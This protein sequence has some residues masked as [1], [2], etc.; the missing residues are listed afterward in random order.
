MSDANEPIREADEGV[1]LSVYLQPRAKKNEIVGLHNGAIKIRITA[2]PVD[3]AANKE[4]IKLL[5]KKLGIAKSQIEIVRG[6]MSR[7][8]TLFISDLDS[9]SVRKYLI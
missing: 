8:K 5:A 2:P 4:L 3:H 6:E 9:E 1:Y 7:T